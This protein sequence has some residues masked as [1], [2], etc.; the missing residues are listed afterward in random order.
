VRRLDCPFKVGTHRLSDG[1]RVEYR[2]SFGNQ[3]L[4]MDKM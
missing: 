1:R 3:D 2:E 4:K